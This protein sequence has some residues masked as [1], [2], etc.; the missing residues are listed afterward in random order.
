MDVIEIW[1]VSSSSRTTKQSV[2]WTKRRAMYLRLAKVPCLFECLLADTL[3]RLQTHK[4]NYWLV[5]L[6]TL[7][8]LSAFGYGLVL[9]LQNGM[10]IE[11]GLWLLVLSILQPVFLGID[12]LVL[13]NTFRLDFS[14]IPYVI[15]PGLLLSTPY[16]LFNTL[17]P[18]FDYTHEATGGPWQFWVTWLALVGALIRWIMVFWKVRTECWISEWK[19]RDDV[20]RAEDPERA[21]MHD[22]MQ[23]QW[24]YVLWRCFLCAICGVFLLKFSHLSATVWSTLAK[25]RQ[26]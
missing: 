13:T 24:D 14:R 6:F 20:W 16:H 2:K 23:K 17:W 3:T 11:G 7:S 25:R 15:F 8:A 12:L 5:G 26:T 10:T 18:V 21:R 1:T 19:R 22:L 4:T 9:S